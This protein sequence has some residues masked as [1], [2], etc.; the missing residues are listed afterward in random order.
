MSYFF[1]TKPFLIPRPCGLSL[2]FLLHLQIPFFFLRSHLPISSKLSLAHYP[3]FPLFLSHFSLF[4]YLYFL[5]F[6]ATT[7]L[8]TLANPFPPVF[9]FYSLQFFFSLF[10]PFHSQVFSPFIFLSISSLSPPSSSLSVLSLS[11]LC[12]YLCVA[13]IT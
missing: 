11:Y 8:L 13:I 6:S 2:F 7:R 9:R 3:T 4:L 1:F 12:G 5:S 10:S